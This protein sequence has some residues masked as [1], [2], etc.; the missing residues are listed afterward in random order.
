MTL[1]CEVIQDLS[2]IYTTTMQ[3]AD[4]YDSYHTHTTTKCMTYTCVY[5]RAVK[6]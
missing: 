3:K 6:H 1:K 5:D 2:P 4:I